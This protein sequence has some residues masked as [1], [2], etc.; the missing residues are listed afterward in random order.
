MEG[1]IAKSGPTLTAT[2]SSEQLD[3]GEAS[4][5]VDGDDTTFWHTAY[6]SFVAKYPHTL[7]LD[8]GAT[9]KGVRG[10]TYLPRQDGNTNGQVARYLVETS[11]DGKIWTKATEGTFDKGSSVKTANFKPSTCR[12]VRLTC[13][14]E[15][16]GQDFASAAE[17][18]VIIAE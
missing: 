16:H 15:Q 14:S 6:G 8:L 7:T 9:K 10:L 1:S 5:A 2:A 11:A 4:H 3:E 12:Y 18:S 17:V 13:L